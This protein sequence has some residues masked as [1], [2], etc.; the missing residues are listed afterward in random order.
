[1]DRCGIVRALPATFAAF[2]ADDLAREMRAPEN[3]PMRRATIRPV[4]DADIDAF[5]TIMMALPRVL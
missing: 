5:A 2:T 4:S 3:Q 1:M